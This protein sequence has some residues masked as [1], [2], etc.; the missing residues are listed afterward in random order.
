MEKQAGI[1][2]VEWI[3]RKKQAGMGREEE[4]RSRQRGR[5]RPEQTGWNRQ[6]K[7]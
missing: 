2:R 3:D 7:I 5:S 1:G 6:N 4:D